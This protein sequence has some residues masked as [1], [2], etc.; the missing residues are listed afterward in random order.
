[1]KREH[2]EIASKFYRA[3]DAMKFLM[4]DKWD[5]RMSECREAIE[6]IQKSHGLDVM[7]ATIFCMDKLAEKGFGG[8]HL[9]MMMATA[10]EILEPM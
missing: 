7:Q 9:A 2:I 6:R 5:S 3:H 1:M 4:D 8:V 10:V